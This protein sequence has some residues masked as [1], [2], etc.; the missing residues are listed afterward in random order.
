MPGL[1]EECREL[2]ET[3][4]LYAVLQISVKST[5]NEV[6]KA[7]RRLS[8][9]VHPDRVDKKEKKAATCK[10]QILGKVY[11][12][13]SDKDKRAVYD[14]TGEVDDENDLPR[15]RDWY[16]YWRTLFMP[17]SIK[18]IQQFEKTY[19]GSKEELDDLKAAYVEC[20]GDL[21]EVIDHVMC[22]TEEDE[23]RFRKILRGLVSGGELP[24]FES[25][26]NESPAKRTLRKKKAKEEAAEAE[27]AKKELGISGE[28][29]LKA[30]IVAKNKSRAAEM[31]SFFD[32][33]EKKYAEP[34][35]KKTK[36]K[37]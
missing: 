23:G 18:D 22:A 1:L 8:L 13:L 12:I 31:D 16:E 11:S 29:S 25:F 24:Q 10:F 5:E 19:K 2:F 35:N 17:I 6:K 32:H 14:E 36:R 20:E 33:L 3:D 27:E 9:K 37:K 28:N 26:S 30:L 34:Q 4:N 15:D 21:G 7:Y